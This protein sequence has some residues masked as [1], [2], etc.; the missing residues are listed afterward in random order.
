M[1][2]LLFV[3]FIFMPKEA[4]LAQAANLRPVVDWKVVA[5]NSQFIAEAVYL[6]VKPLQLKPHEKNLR[7]F[8]GQEF[9][10]TQVLLRKEKKINISTPMEGSPLG[11]FQDLG[12]IKPDTL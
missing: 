6:G 1:K 5:K 3:F 8:E 9:R 12:D 10:V 11:R 4:H 2:I 7:N